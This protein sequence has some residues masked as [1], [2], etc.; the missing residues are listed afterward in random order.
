MKKFVLIIICLVG[1]LLM[2]GCSN[3]QTMKHD[4]NPIEWHDNIITEDIITE[5]IITE[6]IINEAVIEEITIKGI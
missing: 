1:T 3:E 4:E 6:D 5:D 2:T